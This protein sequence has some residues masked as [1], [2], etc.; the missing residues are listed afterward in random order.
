MG[1]LLFL[2]QRRAEEIIHI[3]LH[4]I[5]QAS[6][7]FK[8]GAFVIKALLLIHEPLLFGLQR[9]QA[10]QFSVALYG[11]KSALCRLIDDK[12][13]FVFGTILPVCLPPSYGLHKPV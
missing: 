10:R 8:L 11:E 13:W 9:F 7:L 4:R 6:F 3:R 12:L 1:F 5:N 2:C